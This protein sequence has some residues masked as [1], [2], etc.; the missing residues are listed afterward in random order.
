M[1]IKGLIRYFKPYQPVFEP[2]RLET[3]SLETVKQ[4]L[5]LKENVFYVLLN[6]QKLAVSKWIGPKRTRTYPY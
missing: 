5:A 2:R 1:D 4:G 3:Y 6:G